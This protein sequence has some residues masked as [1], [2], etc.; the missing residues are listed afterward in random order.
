L[1]CPDF[2][3]RAGSA[4]EDAVRRF[5]DQESHV[6]LG[7]IVAALVLVPGCATTQNVR[8]VY[9]DRDFGVIG[10]PENTDEWPTRY[11]R[12]AERLMEQHFPE[13]HEI[14]RAEEVVEGS[15]LLKTEGSKTAEL[16]PQLPSELLKV[17]KLGGSAS[18]SQSD[19]LK[20][21]ECRIIYRRVPRVESSSSEDWGPAKPRPRLGNR[22][23][24]AEQTEFADQA[25]ITPA[26]YLDPNDAERRKARSDA[27]GSGT[28][29]NENE[30]QHVVAKPVAGPPP[31]KAD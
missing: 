10:M 22:L 17:V 30:R 11:R 14:V 29:Q 12:Q 24:R 26:Q 19:T 13:G 25:A 28:A 15:R 4:W 9:Q 20:I 7:S 21:K 16:A 3:V 2:S 18:R 6:Y 5:K 23:A 8:Y 1:S 31:A 27:L